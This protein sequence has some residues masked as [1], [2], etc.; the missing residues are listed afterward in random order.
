[1]L[2]HIITADGRDSLPEFL[3][4]GITVDP[5]YAVRPVIA[6]LSESVGHIVDRVTVC[7]TD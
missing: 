5:V 6:F 4:G 2:K 7:R 1:M 3:L